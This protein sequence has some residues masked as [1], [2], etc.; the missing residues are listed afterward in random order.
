MLFISIVLLIIILILIVLLTDLIFMK[1]DAFLNRYDQKDLDSID[2][3]AKKL[4]KKHNR[5]SI[6]PKSISD[7]E[8][9]DE[10]KEEIKVLDTQRNRLIKENRSGKT[11]MELVYERMGEVESRFVVSSGEQLET[12]RGC[13][14]L[15]LERI[16][17]EEG[18]SLAE[19]LEFHHVEKLPFLDHCI[20]RNEK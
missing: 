8:R 19:F 13:D 4:I 14:Y 17:V 7:Y 2:K 12:K 16:C 20:L 10:I 9:I 6:N 3:R 11:A 18:T 1:I 5:I 15:R